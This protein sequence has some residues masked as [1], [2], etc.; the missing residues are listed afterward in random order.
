MGSTINR[1]AISQYRTEIL[2]LL[3]LMSLT[4]LFFEH[5]YTKVGIEI[6]SIN[7]SV[8]NIGTEIVKIRA[9]I[10][11]T[12]ALKIKSDEEALNVRAIE[13]K[14]EGIR[15]RLPFEKQTSQILSDLTRSDQSRGINIRLIKPLVLE[16]I[17]EFTRVPFQ[18]EMESSFESFGNY[19]S[20]LENLP[21]IIV[22]DNFKIE[23]KKQ[24]ESLLTVQLFVSAYILTY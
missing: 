6:D 9:E 3:V 16:P 8:R 7:K 2:A 24:R 23:A 19:I 14:L 5:F 4:V 15:Q 22:V 17:G 13:T 10:V 18:I 20:Y 12:D 1:A 21:R 11:S